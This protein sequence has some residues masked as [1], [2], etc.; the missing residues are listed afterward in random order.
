MP[1][2]SAIASSPFSPLTQAPLLHLSRK[3]PDPPKERDQG[4]QRDGEL[5]PVKD[6]VVHAVIQ[7]LR[8]VVPES[9]PDGV[10][11]E[12]CRGNGK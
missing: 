7:S 6:L 5:N 9:K 3:P 10:G 8:S 4:Q 1:V 12:A 2:T 11:H